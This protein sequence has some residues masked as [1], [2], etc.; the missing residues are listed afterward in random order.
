MKHPDG[1]LTYS[2]PYTVKA[3]WV[4]I[5]IFSLLGL[6]ISFPLLLVSGRGSSA[7]LPVVVILCMVWA[8]IGLF[9][10]MIGKQKIV[11]MNDIVRSVTLFSHIDMPY[12]D[13]TR[14]EL[15]PVHGRGSGYILQI[16]SDFSG[17]QL[18]INTKPFSKQD[19]S[20][21][22]DVIATHAPSARL[23]SNTRQLRE[24]TFRG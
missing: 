19:I 14:V 18:L 1:A 23:D 3:S 12:T 10:I 13:I 17:R 15:E 16:Y 22:V 7:V 20:I 9:L 6:L 4:P 8:F 11:L 24:G 2:L 5:I 21:V